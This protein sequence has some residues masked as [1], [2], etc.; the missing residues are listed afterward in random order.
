MIRSYLSTYIVKYRVHFLFASVFIIYVLSGFGVTVSN[1]SA[2][3]VAQ[4][5]DMEIW[6]RSSHFTFNLFGVFFYLIFSR[7]LGLSST[8]STELMLS[9]FSLAGSVGLYYFVLN[10][11]EDRRLA[12]ITVLLYALSSGI[13]RFS[14]QTEY[15]V[16]VPSLALISIAFYATKR[17][18]LSGIALALGLLTSPF[19]LL[20]SPAFLLY[21]NWKTLLTKKNY[22]FLAGFLSF[23]LIISFFTFNETIHG[24]WSYDLVFDYYKDTLLK[25]NYIRV[26][27]I[28]AYGYLRSFIVVVPFVLLGLGICY[29]TERSLFYLVIFLGLIHLPLAIPEARYGAYQFTMYP[30]VAILAAIGIN[31]V[32]K[33]NR[34]IAIILL[35]FFLLTNF[36]IVLTE[37]EFNRDLRDTYVMM[38][39]DRTIPQ[40]SILFVYQAVNPIKVLYAPKFKVVS[41]QS[42][43][44]EDLATGLPGYEAQD[45]NSIIESNEH[46]YL[47]ESGTSMPDDRIKLML[48]GFVKDQGAKV[49]GFGKEKLKPYLKDASFYRMNSFPIDVY[50]IKK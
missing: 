1:D 11:F 20:F 12:L 44:L 31:S 38:Q 16:L 43:Y 47:I 5:T 50:K 40:G 10:K 45:L 42:D 37:R 48:S 6:S 39:N 24:E 32:F 13:Y 46:M 15:L 17:Y 36:Y 19:V 9:I 49:K 3:N 41:L 27:S 35:S 2:T 22:L 29:K 33:R 23:Y 26:A 25:I 34:A 4:I 7:T 8:V 18:L 28:W 14:I 21:N 30:F